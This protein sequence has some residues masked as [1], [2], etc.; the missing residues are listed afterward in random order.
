MEVPLEVDALAA[1]PWW[2]ELET[3]TPRDG[4]TE[5]TSSSCPLTPMGE[6]WHVHEYAGTQTLTTDTFYI[7]DAKNKKDFVIC[8]WWFQSDLWGVP[9]KKLMTWL[10][11]GTVKGENFN[12]HNRERENVRK[13]LEESRVQRGRSRR[14]MTSR[15][16]DMPRAIFERG[17]RMAGGRE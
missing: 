7:T 2:P 4:R 11:C 9:V 15:R 14:N 3:Q 13:H 12:V 10:L 6:L 8:L 1:K 17:R 5:Q 16:L